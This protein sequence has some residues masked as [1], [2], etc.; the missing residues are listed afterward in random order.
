[1]L[2]ILSHAFWPFDF[3][4]RRN[5]KSFA[6]FKNQFDFFLKILFNENHFQWF[7]EAEILTFFDKGEG[8]F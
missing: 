6:H 7:F 8:H 1:M 2:I 4:L 5:V 3:V